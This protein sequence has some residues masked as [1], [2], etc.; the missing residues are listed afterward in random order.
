MTARAWAEY[1]DDGELVKIPLPTEQELLD[2]LH[3]V[4]RD[5]DTEIKRWKSR[6]A[7]CGKALTAS[8]VLNV[9]L[10]LWVVLR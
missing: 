2:R 9:A 6:H 1:V 3:E 8:A 5:A 10:F 7:A 4:C